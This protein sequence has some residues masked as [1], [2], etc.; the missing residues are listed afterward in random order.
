MKNKDIQNLRQN[1]TKGTLLRHDLDKSPL[2]QFKAWFEA[3]VD[4]GVKEPNA[5]ILSTIDHHNTPCSR[6]VLMKELTPQGI[7][8]YT[9]LES[10]KA[11]QID[12]K[13]HVSLVFLWKEMERQVRIKG[14]TTIINEEVA[15]KYFQ[16]RPKASQI[17]AW[18][19]AQSKIIKDRTELE[20]KVEKL[21]E[22][23]KHL[24]HLPKPPFWGGYL[25]KPSMFEFWQGRSSRLHDRFRYDLDKNNAWSIVRLNP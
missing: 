18:A 2:H 21:E 15:T 23:Y 11:K 10:A 4:F 22:E 20:N 12:H 8:F 7:I 3:A 14:S 6:T 16:S 9:N 17:G 19:S 13:N 25:I 1:Y 24:D 5:M